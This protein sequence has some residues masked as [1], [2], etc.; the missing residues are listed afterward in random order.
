MSSPALGHP[1][2]G[3]VG[4][5]DSCVL[6]G[7]GSRVRSRGPVREE[8]S[9]SLPPQ[10]TAGCCA[11]GPVSTMGSAGPLPIC[12]VPSLHSHHISLETLPLPTSISAALTLLT[13]CHLGSCGGGGA[14]L[15][16]ASNSHHPGHLISSP[17]DSIFTLSMLPCHTPHFLRPLTTLSLSHHSGHLPLPSPTTPLTHSTSSPSSRHPGPLFH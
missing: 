6:P 15:S 9:C 1:G 7:L 4:S 13:P 8:P 11:R 17:T 10:W 3:P 14:H 12:R 2:S 5:W 16:H